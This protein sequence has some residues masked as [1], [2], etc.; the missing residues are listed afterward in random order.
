MTLHLY[1]ARKFAIYFFSVFCILFIFCFTADLANQLRWFGDITN[2]KTIVYLSFLSTPETV[3]TIMP[4][5]MIFS[6]I[7]LFI[8]LAQ[9]SELVVARA[10]GRS[11]LAFLTGPIFISFLI[12]C[13]VLAIFNPIVAVTSETYLEESNDLKTG[14]T[15]VISIGS[16]GLWLRQGD[17][18]GYTVIRATSANPVGNIFFN[19][20]FFT[21]LADGSPIQRLEAKTAQLGAGEWRLYRVKQWPLKKNINPEVNSKSFRMLKLPTDLTQDQVKDRF[22]K[23][24]S[25]PFWGLPATIEQLKAAGFSARRH[26]V[27]FQAEIARP[28]FLIAMMLLGAAFS[29]RHTRLGGTGMAIL[30]AVVCGFGLFYI[31]NFAQVLGE[32]GQLPVLIAVWTPP[33]ASLLFG[34]SIILHLE[35]G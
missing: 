25:V 1:F 3:Y 23:P 33:I 9:S 10:S 19:V 28:L 13:L 4:L 17:I 8:N 31:R 6:S 2:F 7:W 12:A 11:G 14:G 29:M 32:S 20:S 35:D 34:L 16:D 27:W 21:Y 5:I 26:E 22:E 18:D 30:M 15:S 24:S